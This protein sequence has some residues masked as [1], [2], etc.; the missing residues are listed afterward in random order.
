M[1]RSR[2]K[3]G[4]AGPD[5]FSDRPV[6][7]VV[8]DSIG[9]TAELVTRAALSQFNGGRVEIFRIPYVENEEAVHDVIAQAEGQQ[10][11]I[12]YTLV[13]PALRALMRARTEEAGIPSVDIMGPMMDALASI[14]TGEPRLQPG[15]VH[16]LDEEYFKRVEAIEFAVK[17]DDGRDPRG[18][19]KADAVLIGVSRTS[20]T[21]VSLYLA[22]RGI[23]VANVPLVP[24][25]PEPE[26]LSLLPK[27]RVIGMQIDPI[28]LRQIREERLRTLGLAMGADY[29][30]PGRIEREVEHAG[31]VFRKLGCPV[32][33]VTSRAVE[34][35]A[36][37]V[38]EIVQRH[39]AEL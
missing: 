27:G 2:R 20:K 15:L 6:V 32:V 13:Y 10:C 8:S 1:R 5:L 31:A 11:I 35:T 28:A 34:E 24:E 12:V 19:L 25:I 39:N 22:N 36:S 3:K 9:E 38:L 29:A 23:K 30:D 7:Y 4:A 33:D 17:Y 21:P 16:Q 26:E 37:R 14:V 18:L